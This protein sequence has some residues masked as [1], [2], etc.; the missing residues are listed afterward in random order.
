MIPNECPNRI[1][2][3][4]SIILNAV[5]WVSALRRIAGRA[6]GQFDEARLFFWGLFFFPAKH[7][8]VFL[9]GIFVQHDD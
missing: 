8:T 1:W 2:G 7:V 4:I 9:L 6:S 5:H 3:I